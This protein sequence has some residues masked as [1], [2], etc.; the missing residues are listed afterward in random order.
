MFNIKI[1]N[2]IIYDCEYMNV[3]MLL[4]RILFFENNHI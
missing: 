1:H 4:W 2:T 3:N